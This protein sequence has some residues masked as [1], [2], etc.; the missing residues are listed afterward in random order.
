MMPHRLAILVTHPIQYQVPLF[1]RLAK[2]PELQVKVLYC[3]IPDA[4]AQG[5]EFGIAFQWDIPILEGYDFEVLQEHP[6]SRPLAG[7]FK[8]S[9]AT[10]IRKSIER[11]GFDAVLISGWNA[12]SYF[13]AI[14]V[15]R[16]LGIP[17]LVRGDSNAL[18]RRPWW[19]RWLLRSFLRNFSA[20]L[21]VGK[22]NADYYRQHGAP[23]DRFFPTRH[24]VDNQRFAA[25]ADELAPER[26]ALRHKWAIP[27]GKVCY[28]F[29]AK[30]IVK[31]RPMDF[32]R[33]IEDAVAQGAP[34]HGL[35]VGD[36]ELRP[37]CEKFTGRHKLPATFVG[38]LNQTEIPSAYVAAD[39]LVLPSDYGETWGLVVNE[40]M[41]CAL[42]AVVS[43]RV[44]CGPDLIMEETGRTFPFGDHQVLGRTLAELAHS[45]EKLTTMGQAAR[46]HVENY[47][48]EAA[49]RGIVSAVQF[50]CAEKRGS[51]QE[52]RR[53][54][55]V[56]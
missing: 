17:S 49:A 19:K 7:G 6:A 36:G 45:P 35:L 14:K 9:D 32:L 37:E 52:R 53:P 28:L 40:A 30:F 18:R 54:V 3:R 23:E 38:F 11:G 8:R 50:V 4:R 21:I 25:R 24:F 16:Q 31:K 10:A 29:C 12:R 26:D 55:A 13:D 34:V 20:Y 51:C 1:R 27:S 42:P 41:A 5:N 43:D 48:I 46:R 2:E 47:S 33:A 15:C 44:G 22:S 56:S 39:C